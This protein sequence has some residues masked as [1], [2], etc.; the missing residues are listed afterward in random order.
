M[1]TVIMQEGKKT[2]VVTLLFFVFMFSAYFL[3]DGAIGKA[4]TWHLLRMSALR[5]TVSTIIFAVVLI[6]VQRRK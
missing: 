2:W 3:L 6:L 4:F 1:D 5:A